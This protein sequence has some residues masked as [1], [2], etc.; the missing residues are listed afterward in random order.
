MAASIAANLQNNFKDLGSKK[1]LV[2]YFFF[3]GKSTGQRDYLSAMRGLLYQILTSKPSCVAKVAACTSTEAFPTSALK[4]C[5]KIIHPLIK[6]IPKTF[7]ILDAVDECKVLDPD[8]TQHQRDKKRG[9]FLSSLFEFEKHTPCL[10]TSR[11]YPGSALAP[12]FPKYNPSEISPTHSQPLIKADINKYISREPD[13][14]D[15]L[16]SEGDLSLEVR[17]KEEIKTAILDQAGGMFLYAFFGID[18][19]QG[20]G[21]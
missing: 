5:T 16:R 6:N 13:E 3:D 1:P 15:K 20:L 12:V 9:L 4:K 14:F 10:V 8:L 2:L 7:L 18:Y 21:R 19:I 17:I 11:T